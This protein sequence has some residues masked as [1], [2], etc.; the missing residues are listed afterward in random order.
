MTGDPTTC[1][2]GTTVAEAASLMWERDC[3]I[4]PVVDDGVLTGVVTDRD[5]FIALATR[6]VRPSELT[7]GEVSGRTPVR[8]S[9]EDD[10]ETALAMMRLARVRRLPVVAIDG[11][12]LGLLSMNDFLLTS[13]SDREIR[14]ED[15]VEALQAISGHGLPAAHVVAA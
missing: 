1:T 13:G 14:N 10:V 15:V 2:P 4:L 3:G 9:P 11:K 6:D 12:V 8:C 5:L 7:I